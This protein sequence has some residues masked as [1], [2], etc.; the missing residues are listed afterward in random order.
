MQNANCLFTV[1]LLHHK[2]YRAC[3]IGHIH[4]SF[5]NRCCFRKVY[6]WSYGAPISTWSSLWRHNNSYCTRLLQFFNHFKIIQNISVETI[7]R[8]IVK[9]S[10]RRWIRN[11]W[12]SSFF[13]SCNPHNIGERDN[14]RDD[15]A[16]HAYR[17]D[18]DSRTDQQCH[19]RPI[20]AEH[21]RQHHTH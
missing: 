9:C 10:I 18:D 8:C 20:A 19:C 16:N 13:R 3:T 11:G 1:Y 12:R 6:R 14:I 21:L 2:F 5:Q 4:S 7:A 17:A 15:R